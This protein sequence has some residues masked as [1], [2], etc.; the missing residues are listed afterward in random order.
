MSVRLP[1]ANDLDQIKNIKKPRIARELSDEELRQSGVSDEL[2]ELNYINGLLLQTK[3]S[4]LTPFLWAVQKR[5]KNHIRNIVSFSKP[6]T[7]H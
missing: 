6:A 2:I 4:I 3:W 1:G 5:I 7:T